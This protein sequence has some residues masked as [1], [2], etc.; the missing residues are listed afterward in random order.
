MAWI[1]TVG[2]DEAQ[3]GLKRQYDAAVARSGRV[4]Q[5]VQIMS[6]DPEILKASLLLYRKIM[7]GPSELSRAQREMIAVVVSQAN[8]C[9]Y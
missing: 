5:I 6:L 2:P 9:H 1:R 3:G 4:Y 7:H 8:G